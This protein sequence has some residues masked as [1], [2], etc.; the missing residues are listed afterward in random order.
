[1]GGCSTFGRRSPPRGGP[2]RVDSGV[3]GIRRS[4]G[5]CRAC[6]TLFESG[7][8]LGRHSHLLFGEYRI[9]CLL[10]SF[11]WFAISRRDTQDKRVHLGIC[12]W[13]NRSAVDFSDLL[14]RGCQ[15]VRRNK[16]SRGAGETRPVSGHRVGDRFFWRAPHRCRHS[17]SDFGLPPIFSGGTKGRMTEGRRSGLLLPKRVDLATYPGRGVISGFGS[18]ADHHHRVPKRR[19]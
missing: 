19:R 9:V 17:G 6:P 12:W 15:L 3:P 14:D 4:H 13:R 16:S 18:D 2:S 1:M 5:R 11:C 10:R 7:W 8:I